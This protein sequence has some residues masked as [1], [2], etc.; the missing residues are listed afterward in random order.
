MPARIEWIGNNCIIKYSGE[1]QYQ[2]VID[3]NNQVIGDARF[4]DMKYAIVDYSDATSSAISDEERI[5][6]IELI[7]SSMNWNKHLKA[8]IIATNDY[9]REIS[10][11]QKKMFVLTPWKIKIFSSVEEALP[12]AKS[13]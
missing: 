2:D 10:E 9:F 8:G 5:I 1:I 7:K 12:W 13:K 4:D 3:I 6:I 11:R